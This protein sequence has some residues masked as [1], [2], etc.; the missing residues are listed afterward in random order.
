M[1]LPGVIMVM[2]LIGN[3]GTTSVGVV[4]YNSY[5]EC[6]AGLKR[7]VD[8]TRYQ[9]AERV[10]MDNIKVPRDGGPKN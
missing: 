3:D 10:C 4:P 7:P 1:A 6:Y 2:M 9:W 5:K 8:K